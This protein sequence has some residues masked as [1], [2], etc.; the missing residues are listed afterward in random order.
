METARYPR[1]FIPVRISCSRPIAVAP[2]AVAPPIGVAFQQRTLLR[3]A[4]SAAVGDK[5]STTVTPDG[6]YLPCSRIS[7]MKALSFAGV[8]RRLG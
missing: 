2:R 5:R 4:G 6:G 8:L 3:R 7:S 1:L